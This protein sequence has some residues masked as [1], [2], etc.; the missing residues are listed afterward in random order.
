MVGGAGFWL[1]MPMRGG[2]V[3]WKRS[4]AARVR[5]LLLFLGGLEGLDDDCWCGGEG[6]GGGFC[7]FCLVG[8]GRVRGASRSEDVLEEEEEGKDGEGLFERGGGACAFP[9]PYPLAARVLDFI[10]CIPRREVRFFCCVRASGAMSPCSDVPA[11]G[12]FAS[13]DSEGEERSGEGET[14]IPPLAS[15]FICSSAALFRAAFASACF[16]RSVSARM[17]VMESVGRCCCCRERRKGFP[18]AE[19]DEESRARVFRRMYSAWCRCE[20]K[21]WA[22]ERNSSSTI[23]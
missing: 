8:L 20:V 3:G 21:R 1:L 22:V 4:S 6:K 11:Q 17:A 15:C 18:R 7:C 5:G 2:L 13:S 19:E 16:L 10:P 9:I 23:M 12:C 14:S